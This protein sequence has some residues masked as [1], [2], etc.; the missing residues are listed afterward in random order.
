MAREPFP[1]QWPDGFKRTPADKRQRSKFGFKNSGQVS[2]SHALQELREEV[3]RLGAANVVI[4]SDLPT[5]NDGTPYAPGDK[6]VQDPG[7]AVWCIVPDDHGNQQERVFA[8]DRWISHAE[9]MTGIAKSLD[10]IRGLG[11][12]G[13]ADVVA[14]AMGGFAALPPGSGDEYVPP[15][16]PPKARPWREV[17]NMR[18]SIMEALDKADQIAIAKTRH[19]DAIKKAHP[20][21]GGTHEL[22]AEINA[23]LAAAEQ[24]L[25]K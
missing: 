1:L 15:A 8:C 13:M 14:R 7:I 2:F 21:A 24:E 11:R 9:N 18:G 6:R 23:A 10:A 5:R 12:W 22:A 25:S 3:E 20:D 17:L 19:R 16:P 4:T